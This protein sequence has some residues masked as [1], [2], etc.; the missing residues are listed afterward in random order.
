MKNS[1]TA[2]VGHAVYFSM[3]LLYNVAILQEK[4][5]ISVEVERMWFGMIFQSVDDV[6]NGGYCIGCMACMGMCPHGSIN[7]KHGQLGFPVPIKIEN[8]KSCASCLQ[9]CPANR[10]DDED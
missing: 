7:I 9:E 1:P 2:I 3:Q 4:A 5:V 8:C 6:V 10:N